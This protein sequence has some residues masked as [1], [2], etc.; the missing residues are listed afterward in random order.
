LR[1]LLDTNVLSEPLKPHPSR[2]V[3]ERITAHAAELATASLVWHEL[4]F[5]CARL[6]DSSRRRAVEDY[7][8]DVVQP[9]I[10]VLSYDGV[11]AQWHAEERARLAKAGKAA[12]FVD[13][14]IAAI[15][16][17]N[18]LVL[19]TRNAKDFR[20]YRRLEVVDWSR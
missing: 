1:F 13:G 2:K 20:A 19:V 8:R 16:A 10:P 4:R 9:T 17:V 12:P 18:G 6:P 14:Q 15:A 11:A 5:G 3:L 7:L